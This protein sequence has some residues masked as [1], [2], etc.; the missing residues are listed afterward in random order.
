[1][2]KRL[3]CTIAISSAGFCAIQEVSS[4]IINS[5]LILDVGAGKLA[6]LKLLLSNFSLFRKFFSVFL[7]L[8][9]QLA[10]FEENEG[11]KVQEALLGVDL[12]VA[13]SVRVVVAAYYMLVNF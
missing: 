10:S 7:T 3:V 11:T 9:F 1:M 4:G 2:P 5:T 6:F 12:F 8:F 13:Y